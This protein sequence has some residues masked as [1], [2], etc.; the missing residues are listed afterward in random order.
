MFND[1]REEVIVRFIDIDEIVDNYYLNFL[2][3]IFEHKIKKNT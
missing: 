1:L 3:V 2:V